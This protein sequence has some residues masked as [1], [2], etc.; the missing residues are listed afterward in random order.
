M[1][2]QPLDVG[3]VVSSA[4]VAMSRRYAVRAPRPRENQVDVLAE[5]AAHG[6][7]ELDRRR[8]VFAGHVVRDLRVVPDAGDAG[9]RHRVVED[10]DA[11][12]GHA[13]RS[14]GTGQRRRRAGDRVATPFRSPARPACAAPPRGSRRG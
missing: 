10:G 11:G 7:N 2:S 4:P 8:R 1:P 12:R 9:A 5:V 14:L 6:T 3:P 13:Q